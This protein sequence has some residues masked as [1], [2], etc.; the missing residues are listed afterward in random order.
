MGL[1]YVPKKRFMKSISLTSV[2]KCVGIILSVLCLQSCMEDMNSVK[3]EEQVPLFYSPWMYDFADEVVDPETTIKIVTDGTVDLNSIQVEIPVLKYNKELLFLLSQDDSR[4]STLC[5]TWAMMN[6]RPFGSDTRFQ[7]EKAYFYH[8]ENLLYFDMYGQPYVMPS[9][10]L[11]CTDGAGNEVRFNFSMTIIP[12]LKGFGP[13]R[14]YD[15]SKSDN[16]D[17]YAVTRVEYKGN[18]ES[19]SWND[20][21][22][23]INYGV[24]VSLHDADV[25]T[26]GASDKDIISI[27]LRRIQNQLLDSLN[28][29]GTKMLCEPNGNE[30]YLLAAEE[31]QGATDIAD[32]YAQKARDLYV[33]TAQENADIFPLIPAQVNHD[34]SEAGRRS[35]FRDFRSFGANNTWVD[36]CDQAMAVDFENRQAVSVGVHGSCDSYFYDWLKGVNDK[37]GKDGSDIVWMPSQDEY[38]EYNYYRQHAEIEKTIDG[39][40]IE[41]KIKLP[42]GSNFFYPAATINLVGLDN[43]HVVSV[44]ADDVTTG[45]SYANYD[46][47]YGKG[48]M[49]NID[50]RRYLYDLARHY[51]TEYQNR[52]GSYIYYKWDAKYFASMLKPGL[53]RKN[54]LMEAE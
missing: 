48:F 52:R 1:M 49:V 12:F 28:G 6:G 21:R 20:A 18:D 15:V 3:K 38:Y 2:F 45:M 13:S 34:F 32:S 19:I 40:T 30:Q 16:L 36:L 47:S 43:E 50:C 14:N 39:N 41:L 5:Y 8:I 10:T 27:G 54:L 29:R 25:S 33:L 26:A 51:V 22:Y 24:G 7:T 53:D 42:T 4:H 44:E 11:G 31:S 46:A 17:Q 35:I 23:M 9:K 37:Y